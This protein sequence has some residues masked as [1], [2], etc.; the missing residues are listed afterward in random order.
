MAE[1]RAHHNALE[2]KRRDHIKD[3]F[4]SLRESVPALQGE[5]VAS[6]ALILKKAADY[7]Q[8]MRRKNSAHQQDIDDLKRQN[9]L[10]ESQIRTLEKAKATGNFAAETSEVSLVGKPDAIANFQQESESDTSDSE[11]SHTTRRP[12]KLKVTGL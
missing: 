12:K 6:R 1:K 4:T 10:L 2:R 8:F 3:S 5:K 7:I 9:T 11:T